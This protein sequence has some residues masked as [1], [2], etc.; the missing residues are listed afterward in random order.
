MGFLGALCPRAILMNG[1][2]DRPKT[3]PHAWAEVYI[4][5]P[6]PFSDGS[7]LTCPIRS[8]PDARYVRVATGLGYGDA[9]PVIWAC[10]FGEVPERL[11]VQLQ[12]Q[13]Q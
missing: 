12:V 3:R 7:G 1:G 10:G 4:E 11:E 6:A 9:A 8:C 5:I 2:S 13:Q